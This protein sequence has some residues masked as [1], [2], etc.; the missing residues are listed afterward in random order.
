MVNNQ[1]VLKTNFTSIYVFNRMHV[2]EV[3]TV[4]VINHN[5][6]SFITYAQGCHVLEKSWIFFCC[7]GKFLNFVYKSWKVFGKFSRDLPEQNV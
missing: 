7:P 2:N 1:F 3:K 5:Y 4:F 6:A